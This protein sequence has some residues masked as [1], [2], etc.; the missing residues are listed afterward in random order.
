MHHLLPEEALA[1]WADFP[2]DRQP[3][4]IVLMSFSHG[5]GGAPMLED[6]TDVLR[7][8]AV[9]SDVDI[10]DWLLEALQP[11]PRRQ[12]QG[13]PVRVRS[14][15]RVAPEFRTDRGHRPLPAYRI[16]F[17]GL[18][19]RPGHAPN[20]KA[21]GSGYPP[22]HVID[23]AVELWWPE[24]LDSN[25]RGGLRGLPP[26]VLTD[27]GRTVRWMVH[28]SPPEYTDLWVGAVL[29]SRTAVV[30]VL[31]GATR[32]G[33]EAIPAVAVGRVV[34]AKLTQP[35]ADRVLLQADGIP[36]AVISV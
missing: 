31:D 17:E 22:L 35:L 21:E 15:R 12:R 20:P 24:G 11:D 6:R 32:P 34:M 14:V 19:Y 33:V 10:P 13:D 9:V 4:P 28:G 29:E 8:A 26:A 2:L 7:N 5:P 18:R 23:P 27:R 36:I 3:R 1:W 25:Y 16:E 30:L